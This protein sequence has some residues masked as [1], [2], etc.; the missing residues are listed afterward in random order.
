M[1]WLLRVPGR[2]LRQMGFGILDLP[3]AKAGGL[4]SRAKVWQ[5]TNNS[6]SRPHA[7]PKGFLHLLIP[8]PF[9]G[10]QQT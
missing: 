10:L 2:V 5:F 1:G 4:F 9:S 7:C 6:P 3:V 8:G